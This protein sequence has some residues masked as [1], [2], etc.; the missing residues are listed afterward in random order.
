MQLILMRLEMC[1][2]RRLPL[3]YHSASLGVWMGDWRVEVAECQVV[4]EPH[5]KEC[6]GWGVERRQYWGGV[7]A[8]LGDTGRD[9]T[10]FGGLSLDNI[11]S[12]SP[13]PHR[14]PQ[15]GRIEKRGAMAG[16]TSVR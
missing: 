14:C 9:L 6:A 4:R 13:L 12:P 7:S 11:R 5:G 1:M 16:R 10:G 3:T 2:S 15:H 8:W